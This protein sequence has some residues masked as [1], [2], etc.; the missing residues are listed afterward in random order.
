[1]ACE[2]C[3]KELKGLSS[4]EKQEIVSLAKKFNSNQVAAMKLIRK[5]VVDILSQTIPNAGQSL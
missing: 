3:E 1:M 5:E 2:S 4:A